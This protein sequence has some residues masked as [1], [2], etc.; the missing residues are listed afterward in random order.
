MKRGSLRP[1]LPLVYR[2]ARMLSVPMRT[3]RRSEISTCQGGIGGG[4]FLADAAAQSFHLTVG[5]QVAGIAFLAFLGWIA[6]DG[7]KREAEAD[8]EFTDEVATDCA[9][10]ALMEL[11]K[12]LDHENTPVSL[13]EYW[14]VQPFG[15]RQRHVERVRA[16]LVEFGAVECKLE[17]GSVRYK[18]GRFMDKYV[19]MLMEKKFNPREPATAVNASVGAV[20]QIG[21]GN[22][23]SRVSTKIT[24]VERVVEENREIITSLV[25]ALAQLAVATEAR[26]EHRAE[27]ATLRQE[28]DI[29]QRENAESVPGIGHRIRNL[30]KN[31]S[32][33]ATSLAPLINAINSL[34]DILQ[35]AGGLHR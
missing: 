23:V 17:D 5:D 15:G 16:K 3:L 24:R 26:H 18:G 14:R 22:A 29:A 10:D 27:A 12:N 7:Y 19:E 8:L 21:D 4:M 25:E 13:D 9:H 30:A 35:K 33:S 6:R 31:V 28:L 2:S 20:V 1:E 32:V 34:L 11:Y